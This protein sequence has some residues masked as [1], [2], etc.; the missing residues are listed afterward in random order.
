MGNLPELDRKIE[1]SLRKLDD[2]SSRSNIQI[3]CS[4]KRELKKQ[5]ERNQWN[6]KQKF[7][8]S[9][10]QGFPDSRDTPSTQH[11]E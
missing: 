3:I 7:P 6:N 5:N 8:G 10:R 1:Q 9:E 11:R 4:I 2:Q